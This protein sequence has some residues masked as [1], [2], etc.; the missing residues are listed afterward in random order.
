MGKM[1]P[2]MNPQS[3]DALSGLLQSWKPEV[4]TPSAFNHRVWS[5]IEIS[6][7]RTPSLLSSVFSWIQSMAQPRIAIAAAAV[8]LFGGMLIGGVQA[9]SS[10]EERYLIS[11][12]P[13]IAHR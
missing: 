1:H 6:Q 2:I 13:Y 3:Q 9:R 7:D 5:R 10:Q 8:A 12:N 4:N 11:L